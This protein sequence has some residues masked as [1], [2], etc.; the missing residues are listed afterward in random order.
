MDTLSKTLDPP[1]QRSRRGPER[2]QQAG[3]R[4]G[5]TPA[6]AAARPVRRRGAVLLVAIVCI[7]VASVIFLSILRLSVAERT[8]VEVEA[9]QVQAAWLAESALERAAARLADDP[10]YEGETW[11]L[12]AEDLGTRDGAAVTIRAETIPEQK[13]RRLIRV[14]A[15]YPDHPQH[16]ARHSKQIVVEVKG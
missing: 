13:Q 1:H 5:A 10:D 12:S 2:R 3:N 4:L 7:A 14:E 16:R 11:S 6:A 8:R 15:D 9:W